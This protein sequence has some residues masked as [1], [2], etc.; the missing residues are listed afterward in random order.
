MKKKG[1]ATSAILYT[2]LLLFIT[3]LVG[4]LNNLQNKKTILDALKKDTIYALQQDTVID[5]I[6][7]QLSIIN[8]KIV[9]MEERFHNLEQQIPKFHRI[10][11]SH[12]YATSTTYSYTGVN[13]TIPGKSYFCLSVTDVYG[14]GAPIYMTINIHST[15]EGAGHVVAEGSRSHY[16][17]SATYCGYEEND[18]TYYIWTKR[19]TS[20]GTGRHNTIEFSGFYVTMP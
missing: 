19:T 4:I 13:K 17:P 11:E 2:I 18:T 6:L 9:D 12:D 20:E 14:S 8:N 7:D 10:K 1:F 15:S 5:A 3:L 16:N